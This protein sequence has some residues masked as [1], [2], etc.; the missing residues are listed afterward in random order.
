[1]H[2]ASGAHDRPAI[3]CHGTQYRAHVGQSFL[4]KSPSGTAVHYSASTP[5]ATSSLHIGLFAN[6]MDVC[7]TKDTHLQHDFCNGLCIHRMLVTKI[8]QKPRRR[9]DEL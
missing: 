3:F 8:E 5:C 1:M 2:T 7:G 9:F 4:R 6:L